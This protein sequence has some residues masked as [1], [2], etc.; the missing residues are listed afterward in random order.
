MW[1]NNGM[2]RKYEAIDRV[3][4]VALCLYLF[5]LLFTKGEGIKNML[6]FG[7][8]ILWLGT[9]RYRKNLHVLK[10]P[11]PMLGCAFIAS[12]VISS[13]F[14]VDIRYSLKD[15]KDDILKSLVLFPVIATV[16]LDRK[17]LV[18]AMYSMFLGLVCVVLIG[19]YSY[20]THDI[21]MMRPHVP[22]LTLWH[23]KFARYLNTY[24]P[25]AFVLFF[26]VEK[27][28]QKAVL[29]LALVA[30]VVAL[31]LTTS[32]GAYL[33]FF[34]IA[35]V[36]LG[37]LARTRTYDMKK[38]VAW[39]L[40]SAVLLFTLSWSF[41]PH[42]R[43]RMMN[44]PK[45]LMTFNLRTEA[46]TAGLA[47]FQER[48]V[49]GWGYGDG[50]FHRDEPYAETIYKK[51]PSIGPHSTFL[52]VLFHQG[53]MGIISYVTLIAVA[54]Y[55]LY[56]TLPKASGVREKILVASL[57]VLVGNYVL[58]SLFESLPLSHLAIV[59]GLSNAARMS[60][61]DNHTE[62]ASGSSPQQAA[63]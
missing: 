43:E 8:F 52:R 39:S 9:L 6:L 57:S 22:I 38:V 60:H 34:G 33:A 4:E 56:R 46:W 31:I 25:F 62:D 7:S 35:S 24:L 54:I 19:Y 16:F 32:R 41:S 3:I 28:W 44:L 61:E 59:L 37:F 10:D 26:A 51:A 12:A 47:A 29:I 20:F 14:S 18:R 42:L 5:L 49:L 48:P 2:D 17:R 11:V 40:V 27:K 53:L 23:N 58:H 13:I 55:V 1:K 21:P 15:L 30:S 45:D 63:G 36:W 50:I